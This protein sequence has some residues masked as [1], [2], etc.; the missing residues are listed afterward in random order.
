[1]ADLADLD[2][3]FE[4]AQADVKTLTTRPSSEQLLTLYA[5]FKQA[6]A[7]EASAAKKPGRFDIVGT[8]KYDAW[9]RLAGIP[10]DEAKTRYIATV[11]GLLGRASS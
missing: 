10:A 5:L 2:G 3:R 8:A 1:V 4:Q 6:S 9:R 7:G 11:D